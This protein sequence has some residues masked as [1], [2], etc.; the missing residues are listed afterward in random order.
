MPRPQVCVLRAQV[1]DIE[2]LLELWSRAREEF[3][4]S[5]LSVSTGSTEHLRPRLQEALLTGAVHVLIAT[6]EGR[7]VGYVVLTMAPVNP[8]VDG[9]N[10]QVEHLWVQPDL[11]HHGVAKSLLS[12]VTAV[13]ETHGCEQ[14]LVNVAP[15]ARESHRFLARLGFM[16]YVTRRVVP[17]ATLRRKLSGQARRGGL[18]DLLSLRRS[19]RARATRLHRTE[20]S[21]Q[22]AGVRPESTGPATAAAGEATPSSTSCIDLAGLDRHPLLRER[23]TP[24]T[25]A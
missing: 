23:A 20:A 11:R 17:T 4:R 9:L 22:S 25:G 5:V 13:A 19:Q 1:E 16:P 2:D 15:G 18:E 8:L 6:Y 7:P 10:L 12:K 24:R 14:V 21:G 3:A